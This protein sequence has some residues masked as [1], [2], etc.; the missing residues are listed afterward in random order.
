MV[1]SGI[2][3]TWNSETQ[4]PSRSHS[5]SLYL[6]V[7]DVSRVCEEEVLESDSPGSDSASSMC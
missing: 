6:G 3:W 2:H 5:F 1:H 7:G 4:V